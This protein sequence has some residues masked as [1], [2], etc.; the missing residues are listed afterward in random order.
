MTHENRPVL[1][2]PLVVPH[3]AALTVILTAACGPRPIAP[4]APAR[5]APTPAR[6]NTGSAGNGGLA[7]PDGFEAVVVHDGVG[8]AR[9][10]AVTDDG[11]VYV[12][13]RV[14][15]PKGLV[16]LRDTTGRRPRRRGPGVRRVHRHRR[17]R[18]GDAHPRRAHLLHDRRRGLPA[19]P[20]AGAA[21]PDG[22]GRDRAP[23]RVQEEPAL[24]RAH[25]QAD[26]LRRQGPH[27]RAVRGPGR[28]LPG[29]E[30][31]AGVAG[32][33]AVPRARMAGRRLAVQRQPA[34]SDRAGRAPLRDRDPQPGRDVVEPARRRALRAAARPRRSLPDVV[35]LLHAL[36]ERGAAVGGVLQGH[37]RLRRRLAVLLLR[38]AA[39]GRRS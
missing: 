12:K 23:A 2:L 8:R 18:H 10:L 36:A 33:T 6:A 27:V 15:N 7:L 25:R 37:R 11:I 29:T 30:P 16:A 20:H 1:R 28:H 13:L 31:P 24:L 14:P 26:R 4:A 34:Q 32:P 21:G 38:P 5:P 22:P 9:H 35:A 19:A 3:A 17:L 39:R